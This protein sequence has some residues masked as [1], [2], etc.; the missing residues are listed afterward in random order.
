[1]TENPNQISCRA[2]AESE[3]VHRVK[4]SERLFSAS[5]STFHPPPTHDH[6]RTQDPA[7]PPRGP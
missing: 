1:M 2:A 7:Q 3:R 5:S 4:D 6:A